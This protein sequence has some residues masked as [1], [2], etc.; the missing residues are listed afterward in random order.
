[1]GK[2]PVE[3]KRELKASGQHS[4]TFDNPDIDQI[5]D[6]LTLEKR[7]RHQ[8][9]NSPIDIPT[10]ASAIDS[11][12]K[13]AKLRNDA[14][15]SLSITRRDR[16]THPTDQNDHETEGTKIN[17]RPAYADQVRQESEKNE[18]TSTERSND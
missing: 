11:L 15:K 7:I 6:C 2:L 10:W 5:V 4:S 13:L 17:I 8:L 9:L 12:T 14:A 3:M 18:E 16:L 1:M